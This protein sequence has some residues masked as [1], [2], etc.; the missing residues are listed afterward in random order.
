MSVSI[1][2]CSH[3]TSGWGMPY[4]LAHEYNLTRDDVVLV[5]SV[6]I[7]TVF[8]FLNNNNNCE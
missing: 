8:L 6:R 7:Y 5:D 2:V 1:Q 3:T 4:E